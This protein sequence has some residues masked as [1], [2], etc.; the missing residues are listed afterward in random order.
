[1]RYAEA[2]GTA[3][4]WLKRPGPGV[5]LQVSGPAGAGKTRLLHRLRE[6][7]PAGVMVDCRG[8]TADQVAHAVL[9]GLG[10]HMDLSR[11]RTPLRDVLAR[12]EGDAL[13]VLANAQ[14]AGPLFSS[15]EPTRVGGDLAAEIALRSGGRVSV[16][17]E[18]DGA[19]ERVAVTRPKDVRLEGR[20]EPEEPGVPD[21]PDGPRAP[22]P[23]LVAEHPALTALAAAE[24]RAVSLPVWEFLA[25]AL[26]VPATA[27]E[28]SGL[29]ARQP[30]V[31]QHHTHTPH[32]TDT[33]HGPAVSFRTDALKHLTRTL[34]PLTPEQQAAVARQLTA[35]LTGR[36]PS[37]PVHA[38]A[39]QALA[40]H[41]ALSGTGLPA[42]L[43]DAPAAL[44]RCT[45]Y[46]VLQA[47]AL[48]Y[49]D[50]VSQGGVAADIHYLETEGIAP[51]DQGEWLSWLHWAATNRGDTAWA[52][53]LAGAGVPLPW[54]TAW[55]HHRPYAVFGPVPGGTGTVDHLFPG[56][57]DGTAA[58][59]G[60]HLLPP[61]QDGE[62]TE[63]EGDDRA[64]ER[65]WSLADGT[66]L[67][68]PSTVELFYDLEGDVE[69]VEGRTARFEDTGAPALDPDDRTPIRLPYSATSS[70]APDGERW[71]VAGRGGLY[72]LDPHRPA[73]PAGDTPLP[74]WTPPLLAPHTSAAP[75]EFPGELMTPA[76]PSPAVLARAFGPDA[77]RTLPASAVPPGLDEATRRCLTD[78]G[79]PVLHGQIYLATLP[80]L[81][82][83]GL[84]AADWQGVP[85]VPS[86]GDGPFHPLGTWLGSGAYL[87][88]ATGRV[89]QDGRSGASF[90]LTVA[91]SLPQYLALLCLYRTFVLSDFA[92]TAELHD[93]R[94]ALHRWAAR[95]DP[96]VE[97]SRTWQAILSGSLEDDLVVSGWTLPGLRPA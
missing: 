89:L 53:A 67:T 40:P 65:I 30:A 1:M 84:P 69:S 62:Y 38:Y 39:A 75:W 88:A 73:P 17:V 13:V 8:L 96:A 16:A 97:H 33:S 68:P 78:T 92:C 50:G 2:L 90:E 93:A 48:H 31:L 61:Y 74:P 94:S 18:V 58:V 66:E 32:P 41:A 55:S 86:P 12:H 76:G 28:L 87:D 72:A 26:G 64:V 60:Q 63:P 25:R 7:F 34:T 59:A 47:L 95:I 9:D 4:D 23:R 19:H 57:L 81:D 35:A 11:S 44:A 52:A 49:R 36:P 56:S 21:G 91:G 22:L 10:L 51:E 15:T 71:V 45:R 43:T 6:R 82:E 70:C 14:W 54:R 5:V 29:A 20:E 46:S 37:D 79:V 80:P 24:T 27:T 42:L 77:C 3:V 83:T 85:A